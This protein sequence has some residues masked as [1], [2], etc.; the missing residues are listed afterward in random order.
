[1]S[2][3]CTSRSRSTSHSGSR[4][5]SRTTVSQYLVKRYTENSQADSQSPCDWMERFGWEAWTRTR[6]ARSRVWSPT[7]W[8]TSQLLPTLGLT[9]YRGRNFRGKRGNYSGHARHDLFPVPS[10]HMA[11]FP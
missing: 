5:A 4:G 11:V 8:T 3:C 10:L 1:M 2:A 7:D 6:I 9:S